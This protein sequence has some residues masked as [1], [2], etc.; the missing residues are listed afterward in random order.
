M[1]ERIYL[2]GALVGLIAFGAMSGI[3]ALLTGPFDLRTVLMFAIGSVVVGWMHATG[4]T[5]RTRGRRLRR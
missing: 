1:S 5:R 2:Q 4:R 3:Y